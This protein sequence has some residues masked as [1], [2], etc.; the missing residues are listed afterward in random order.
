M[1][2]V[3]VTVV[4][5]CYIYHSWLHVVKVTRCFGNMLLPQVTCFYAYGNMLLRLHVVMVTCCCGNMLLW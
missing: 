4:M 3:Y 2:T 1:N 5:T